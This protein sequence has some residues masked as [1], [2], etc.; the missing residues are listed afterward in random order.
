MAEDDPPSA[1]TIL[2]SKVTERSY[3]TFNKVAKSGVRGTVYAIFLYAIAVITGFLDLVQ[4]FF[5]NAATGVG[6]VTTETIGGF[7]D[8][9]SSGVDDT[10]NNLLGIGPFGVLEAILLV[11][12]A[13]FLILQA[14]QYFDTD[15]FVIPGA[16]IIPF[17]GEDEE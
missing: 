16:N 7:A 13:V 12:V 17:V 9:I 5:S 14:Q 1:S 10:A 11:A 8:I 15:F 3:D 2:G 6:D 4:T